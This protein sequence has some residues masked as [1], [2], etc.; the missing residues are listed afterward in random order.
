MQ[1]IELATRFGSVRIEA[2]GF[3][4]ASGDA[5]LSYE[6]GLDV[7]EPDAPVYGSLNFLIEGYDTEGRRGPGDQRRPRAARRS[8]AAPTA[9][10]GTT[11]S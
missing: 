7:R 1:A 8:A 5:T 2:N 3:V 4:D 6:A 11:A 9:S 10:C